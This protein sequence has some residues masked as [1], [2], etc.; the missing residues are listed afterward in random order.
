MT[1]FAT[2][3]KVYHSRR[4]VIEMPRSNG[5]VRARKLDKF[6]KKSTSGLALFYCLK[7]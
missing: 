4:N 7:R 6:K 1:G 2:F 3:V 5:A